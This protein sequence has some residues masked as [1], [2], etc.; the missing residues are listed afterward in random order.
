[1][2]EKVEL[3]DKLYPLKLYIV[4]LFCVRLLLLFALFKQLC[5]NIIQL[6]S[7]HSKRIMNH[8]S[9]DSDRDFGVGL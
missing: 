3:N 4:L 2:F 9:F 7:K 5:C 6:F 8:E 1:M